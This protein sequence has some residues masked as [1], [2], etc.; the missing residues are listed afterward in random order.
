[1]R[2]RRRRRRKQE[3]EMLEIERLPLIRLEYDLTRKVR[4]KRGSR[5]VGLA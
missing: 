2:G 5:L 3:K 4:K 1:M